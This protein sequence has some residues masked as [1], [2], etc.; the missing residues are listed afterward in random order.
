MNKD[1][2]SKLFANR[3]VKPVVIGSNPIFPA[4]SSQK[5]MDS[6]SKVERVVCS[7]LLIYRPDQRMFCVRMWRWVPH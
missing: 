6:S 7:V 3:S 2:Y 5:E 1:T 4:R